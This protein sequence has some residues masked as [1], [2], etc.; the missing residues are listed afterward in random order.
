MKNEFVTEQYLIEKK[1]QNYAIDKI[2]F[3]IIDRL[4]KKVDVVKK[5]YKV[6]SSDLSS[7]L[8]NEEIE[9]TSYQELLQLLCSAI[10]LVK[11]YKFLNTAFKLNELLYERG[12]LSEKQAE[13]NSCEL[14]NL[15]TACSKK[16]LGTANE[17]Y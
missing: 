17:R 2:D 8:S 3:P 11:D 7:K 14:I 6:Y 15:I 4:C 5:V 1:Y 9:Y 12:V 16:H 10:N 13:D